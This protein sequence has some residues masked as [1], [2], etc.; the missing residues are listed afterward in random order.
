MLDKLSACPTELVQPSL[1]NQ[2]G[3]NR[4]PVVIP[5]ALFPDIGRAKDWLPFDII[6]VSSDASTI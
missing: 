4:I 3:A 2:A 6:C 1:A 5:A